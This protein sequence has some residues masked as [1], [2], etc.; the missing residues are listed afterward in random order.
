MKQIIAHIEKHVSENRLDY[1][2]GFSL[3][4]DYLIDMFD[5]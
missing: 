3:F 5:Y 2:H 1:N 4:V